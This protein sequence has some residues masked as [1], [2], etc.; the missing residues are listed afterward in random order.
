[1]WNE[2]KFRGCLCGQGR[3]LLG[4]GHPGTSA[5]EIH[6]PVPVNLE[7][8]WYFRLLASPFFFFSHRSIFS[9]SLTLR[10]VDT[11]L[12]PSLH[13]LVP[14]HC[15]CSFVYPRQRQYHVSLP[16]SSSLPPCT[17]SH[18]YPDLAAYLLGIMF[19]SMRFKARTRSLFLSYVKDW[20]LVIVI[21]AVFSYVDTLEPFHRQFSVQDMSIQHPFAKKE[22]VPVWM[23]LVSV[24]IHFFPF[25]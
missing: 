23:A 4:C 13:P 19:S 24:S 9:F 11:C 1:M 6:Q 7:N 16:H 20:G 8:S 5:A 22:T 14:V 12:D 10:S 2:E 15:P 21:L 17:H 18:T 3:L 25:C